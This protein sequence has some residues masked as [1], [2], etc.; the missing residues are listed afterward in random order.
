MGFRVYCPLSHGYDE[1][2]NASFFKDNGSFTSHR[3]VD[4]HFL[5]K[6]GGNQNRTREG[7]GKVNRKNK[8]LRKKRLLGE[9]LKNRRQLQLSIKS[10]NVIC[11]SFKCT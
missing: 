4:R 8:V 2:K 1:E 7:M 9:M 6:F 3:C 10:S 5:S 11:F